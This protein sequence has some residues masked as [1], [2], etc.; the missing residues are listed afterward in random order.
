LALRVLPPTPFRRE[1]RATNAPLRTLLQNRR[2]LG[3]VVAYGLHNSEV[4]IMRA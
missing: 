2:A 3:F 4:S 1:P